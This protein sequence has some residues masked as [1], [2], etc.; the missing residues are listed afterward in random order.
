LGAIKVYNTG[1]FFFHKYVYITILKSKPLFTT[2]IAFRSAAMVRKHGPNKETDEHKLSDDPK[3][4][5]N[6][7]DLFR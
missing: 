1:F 2:T 3:I 7:T 4:K 5:C 6:F